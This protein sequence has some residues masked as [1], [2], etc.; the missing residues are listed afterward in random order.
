MF[1]KNVGS[2][3]RILRIV[4]GL[5]L[6]AAFFFWP[7]AS[8]YRWWLL[9]GIVPLATAFINFCPLYAITGLSTRKSDDS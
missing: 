5:V 2:A 6:L 9:I 3:D 1:T 7:G 8:G 4:L